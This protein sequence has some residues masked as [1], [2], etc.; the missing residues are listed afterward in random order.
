MDEEYLDQESGEAADVNDMI[1]ATGSSQGKGI[2]FFQ[3]WLLALTRP[4]ENTYQTIV[5]DPGASVGRAALWIFITSLISYGIAM[6]L[7]FGQMT[8]ML[9]Q[10]EE[11]ESALGLIAGGGAVVLL[12][13]LP[14]VATLA[15]VGAMVYAAILQFV[16]GALGGEGSFR[17]LFFGTASYTAPMTII[18]TGLSLIPFVGPCLTLPLSLYTA[19]LNVLV[20]KAVNRFGWGS[21]IVTLLVPFIVTILISLIA[22]A[23]LFPFLQELWQSELGTF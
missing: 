5:G 12:C 11:A 3:I 16:A 20:L 23:L 7:Q 2:M 19:Y 21:A 8:A 9:G 15:V 14:L 18:T 6:T 1:A 17:D 22:L 4:Q 13:G 10:M